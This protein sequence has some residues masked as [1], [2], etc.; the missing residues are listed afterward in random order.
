MCNLRVAV[1]IAHADREP[2]KTVKQRTE[3]Q[4]VN[5]N[6]TL[7]IETFYAVGIGSANL[8]GKIRDLIERV[9]W[10]RAFFLLRAFD[11]ISLS[12]YKRKLPRIEV[13]EREFHIAVPEDIR[14][15]TP[16]LLAAYEILVQREFDWVVRTTIFSV[17]LPENL[18]E[19]LSK[20]PIIEPRVGGKIVVQSDQTRFVSGAFTV[21]NRAALIKILSA[22]QRIKLELIDDVAISKLV[23]DL[24]IPVFPIPSM[25]IENLASLSDLTFLE[26]GNICHIRCRSNPKSNSDADF[27]ST[28]LNAILQSKN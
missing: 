6:L 18:I 8:S 16:K 2:F 24:S 4:I 26:K 25:N 7:G 1:L 15:L 5:F 21:F 9:R 13:K 14:H 10:T 12:R 22:K 3:Q 11:M 23:S 19:Y 20:L 17:V 27:Y 28:T